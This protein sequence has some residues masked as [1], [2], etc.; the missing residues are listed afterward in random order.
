[1]WETLEDAYNLEIGGEKATPGGWGREVNS[2][3]WNTFRTLPRRRKQIASK[4]KKGVVFAE[5][6]GNIKEELF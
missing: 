6:K 1:V 4:K 2:G 5:K 3:A